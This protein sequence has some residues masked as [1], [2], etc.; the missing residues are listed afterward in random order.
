M[1]TITTNSNLFGQAL[2]ANAIFSGASGILFVLAAGNLSE[3]TGIQPPLA[4]IIIG[5]GLMIYS[6]FLFR[7]RRSA[8]RLGGHHR[9]P[10]VGG[11]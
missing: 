2:R 3:L 11:R 9:R 5:I 10:A 4:F 6:A 1:T 7:L 8:Y